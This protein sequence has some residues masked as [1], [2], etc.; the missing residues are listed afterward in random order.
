MYTHP[1]PSHTHTQSSHTHL[2]HTYT[3]STI[4]H[5]IL[6][7]T[8]LTHTHPPS[9]T[10]TQSSLLLNPLT[11]LAF[12]SSFP[13]IHHPTHTQTHKTRPSVPYLPQIQ[14]PI[15]TQVVNSYHNT[16]FVGLQ[17]LS[18]NA[19][20]IHTLIPTTVLDFVSLKS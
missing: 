2:T 17:H 4:T 18:R 15:L 7:N 1:P 20:L 10:H 11:L 12:H 13:P 5:T 3:T 19:S 14:P 8:P 16:P 9:H 6:A